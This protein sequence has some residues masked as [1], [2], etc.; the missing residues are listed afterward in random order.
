MKK[1]MAA[2]LALAATLAQAQVPAPRFDPAQGQTAEKQATDLT[3]CGHW[4]EQ[5]TG[6]SPQAETAAGE[7]DR[8]A[9]DEPLPAGPDWAAIDRARTHLAHLVRLRAERE[10]VYLRGTAACMQAR[11]YGVK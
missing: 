1:I 7:R 2:S 11:G 9:V 3:E 8:Q 6:Y 5:Q 4:S 10:G